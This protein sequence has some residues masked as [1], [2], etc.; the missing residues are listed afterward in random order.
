[1]LILLLLKREVQ[2]AQSH[3]PPNERRSD[4]VE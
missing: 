3:I 4:L 2:S 1:V